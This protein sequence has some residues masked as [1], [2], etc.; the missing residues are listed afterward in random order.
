MR[1]NIV[2]AVVAVLM[3]AAASAWAQ[4]NQITPADK[5]IEP[6][7]MQALQVQGQADFILH[8]AQQAD[9]SPAY[10]MD[11]H[12]RGRFVYDALRKNA[13]DSQAQA[14]Q[15]LDE[16]GLDY[17]SF[18]TS[19]ELYVRGGD[20]SLASALAGLP[21]VTAATVPATYAIVPP[22][23][24]DSVNSQPRTSG[25]L[26]W[27]IVN[28]GADQFW[29]SYG[30]GDGIVVA[31]IDTGVQWNHP[32][33]AGA[34]KCGSN[35]ADPDCWRDPSNICGAGGACDNDGHGTHVM[36]TMVGDNDPALTWQA[37]VAPGA[38]W[39]ACKG[40]ESNS[41]SAFAL[42]SCADW[43]IAPGGDPDNRPHV[44]NNSWGGGSGDSWY[45][46][47]VNAW[48]AAGIFPAFSAGNDGIYGCGTIGTP[49]DYQESFAS[50][51]HDS[52]GTI[53]DFSSRGPSFFGATPYTKPNISAPGV[54][55]CSS[56]PGDAWSCIYSGTSMASPHTAGAVALLWACSPDLRGDIDA[57]IQVLQS[58]AGTTPAGDCG[59]PPSGQGNYTYGY[60]HLDVLA[61]GAQYC[62]SCDQC[63]GITPV[64]DDATGSCVECLNNTHCEPGYTCTVNACVPRGTMQA[65]AVSLK[66]GKTLDTD[67]MKLAGSLDATDADL[68]NAIGGILTVT[69]EAAYIPSPGSITYTFQ[70]P[71]AS[72]NDGKYT[73]PKVI[74][75]NKADPVTSFSL[76]TATGAMKFSAR[77]VDLTGLKCPITFSVQFG[78]YAA[79][80]QL[81]EVIVN[82]TKPCPLPLVMGVMDSLDALKVS[83]KKGTTPGTD[84]VKISGS[85]T[86]DGTINPASPV[87]ITLGSDTFTVPGAEFLESSGKY[88]CKSVNSGNAYISARFDTVKC[89]YSIQIKAADISGSGKVSFGINVFGNP[90]LASSG[91]TLPL[92][93]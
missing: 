7:L 81:S 27:G 84:S 8:F 2:Q 75:L 53:A 55:V 16:A 51:A 24:D 34:Y 6:E 61:A 82:G 28:T 92:G 10:G 57:T 88:S 73:S 79:E 68:T 62:Q 23:I 66:A 77:N 52:S 87:V 59:A 32:A 31:N 64:C 54:N 13:D 60:G 70:V 49:G 45:I 78:D 25:T 38:T 39:I 74:P 44:V 36:G 80:A 33:L 18:F 91:V 48:R 56:V 11:W 4:N 47:K 69:I 21:E 58:T 17:V 22:I 37:G 15:L 85:F 20:M 3:L 9:L 63:R 42:N 90:L 30:T 89:T 19:N 5:K 67:S 71:A 72:V 29:Q 93:F 26:A 43:I 12:A 1:G 50:A 46:S 76:D 83:G 40:C 14:R 35:P 41:C 65:S 86:I